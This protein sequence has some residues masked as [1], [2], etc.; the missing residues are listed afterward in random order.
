[1][2]ADGDTMP[3][4]VLVG[5]FD[6]ISADSRQIV[7]VAAQQDTHTIYG[8]P[9]WVLFLR[10]VDDASGTSMRQLSTYHPPDTVAST[11]QSI[12]DFTDYLAWEALQARRQP[13]AAHS[14][15]YSH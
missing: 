11:H 1:M 4:P 9:V 12:E 15:D 3:W 6:A 7:T 5:Y 10:D 13:K 2:N 8:L 14:P